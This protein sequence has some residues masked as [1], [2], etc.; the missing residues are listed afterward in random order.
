VGTKG[1]SVSD[2]FHIV[3]TNIIH[4][5]IHFKE[6]IIQDQ[7]NTSKTFI[8]DSIHNDINLALTNRARISYANV[9]ESQ[10]AAFHR[11]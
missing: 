7:R 4:Y 9:Q 2:F 5:H 6:E 11:E 1:R 10:Q 3:I 8:A